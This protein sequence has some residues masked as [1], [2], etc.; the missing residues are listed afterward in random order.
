[1]FDTKSFVYLIELMTNW[2]RKYSFFT[3]LWKHRN[4]DFKINN[5]CQIQSKEN[6]LIFK[7][8]IINYAS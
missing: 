2:K 4:V 6:K 1:M 5:I 3:N 7:E 8:Q